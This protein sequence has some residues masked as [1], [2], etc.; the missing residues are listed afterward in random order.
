MTEDFKRLEVH[1]GSRTRSSRLFAQKG[2]EA[3]MASF[4][5]A[6]REGGQPEVTVRDGVRATVACLRMLES[7][8]SLSPCNI[9]VD[10]LAQ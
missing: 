8:R 3:Q 4:V 1:A 6:I 2:Y 9:D 7:A 10:A 5:N